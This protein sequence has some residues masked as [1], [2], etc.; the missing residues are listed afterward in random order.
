[1]VRIA[2]VRERIHQPFFDTLL[3]ADWYQTPLGRLVKAGLTVE[4]AEAMLQRPK[5]DPERQC[6]EALGV[7]AADPA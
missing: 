7:F 3:R 6:W 2:S 5:D 1:M 4:Q